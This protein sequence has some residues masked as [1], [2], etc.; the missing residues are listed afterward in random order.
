[1][2]DWC[3]YKVPIPRG[4]KNP[5]EGDDH[6][7]H[8]ANLSRLDGFTKKIIFVSKYANNKSCR[9]RMYW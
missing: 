2:K 7:F 4:F 9:Y 6:L 1:M 8:L 3:T 5:A